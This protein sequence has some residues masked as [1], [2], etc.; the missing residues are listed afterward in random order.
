MVN[1]RSR[2]SDRGLSLLKV[3]ST[4]LDYCRSRMLDDVD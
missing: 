1:C 2:S 4:V 3:Y